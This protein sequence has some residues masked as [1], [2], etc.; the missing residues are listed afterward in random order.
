MFESG[1]LMDENEPPG[2][3]KKEDKIKLLPTPHSVRV[4]RLG[5]YTFKQ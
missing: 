5:I 1:E 3:Q 4:S 2:E